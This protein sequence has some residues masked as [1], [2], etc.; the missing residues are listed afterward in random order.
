[1]EKDKINAKILEEKKSAME[2][3]IAEQ[4]V[5]MKHEESEMNRL[6]EELKKIKEEGQAKREADLHAFELKYKRHQKRKLKPNKMKS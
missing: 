6:K 5:K 3:I 4:D 1:M 2:K